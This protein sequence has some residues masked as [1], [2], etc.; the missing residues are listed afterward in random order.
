MRERAAPRVT[1]APMLEVS[2]LNVHYG[3]SHALQ[4][5]DLTL[6]RG[7]LSVVGRNGMGKTTLCKAIMGLVRASSGS[8]RVAGEELIGRSPA[9]IARVGI[10]YVPQGRRLWRT[11][12]VDEHLRLVAT[13]RGLWSVERI[14]DTFPRLAERKSNR[15]WQLSGG[16]QQMLAISRALLLNP[17]LLVM[18]EPT[19]GP[20]AG[21]R[22][23]GRG[24]AGPACGAGRDVRAGDRTEYRRRDRNRRERGHHG[25]WP[26]QS[27]HSV[28]AAC[29]RSRAAAAPARRRPAWSRRHSACARHGGTGWR[30]PPGNRAAAHLSIQSVHSDALVA[31]RGGRVDRG[32]GA[33]LVERQSAAG[34]S[35]RRYCQPAPRRRQQRSL[36][37]RGRHARHQGRGDQVP[38]RSPERARHP[39]AA[40]RSVDQRQA[41]GGRCAADRDRAQS[42]AWRE[43]R[44]HRRSRPLGRGHGRSLRELDPP[45]ARRSPALFPPAARAARRSRRRRCARCRSACRRS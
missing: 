14:Y 37:D 2:G 29:G 6:Q 44:V 4:G 10:G 1:S 32:A 18:D 25:Q 19:E 38:P 17:R 43:R 39:H 35:G 26:H 11:L 15:A 3:H 28:G 9:D 21:D 40:G 24:H 33:H 30:Y 13:K 7:V 23:A 5:V 42:P 45:P 22:L 34:G 31:A 20:R 12:T 16:E 8:I 27:R 41:L 36:C